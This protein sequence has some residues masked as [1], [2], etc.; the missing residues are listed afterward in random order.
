VSDFSA[1][2]CS[3]SSSLRRPAPP[4][5]SPSPK[6]SKLRRRLNLARI[7]TLNTKHET[8]NTPQKPPVFPVRPIDTATRAK[9]SRATAT[10]FF[11][12]NFNLARAEKLPLYRGFRTSLF[13]LQSLFTRA[14]CYTPAARPCLLLHPNSYPSFVETTQYAKRSLS[15]P[16]RPCLRCP[17]K[18]VRSNSNVYL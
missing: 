17:P 16:A 2:Q 7:A 14:Y 10:L 6:F 9:N 13:A 12:P 11:G 3:K 18:P 8:P 5:N 1:N 15:K 4:A